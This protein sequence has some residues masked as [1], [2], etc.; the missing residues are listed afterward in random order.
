M[1]RQTSTAPQKSTT[2]RATESARAAGTR[3]ALG[4]LDRMAPRAA[5]RW[6]ARIWCTVP[7][8]AL[9]RDDRPIPGLFVPPST[10]STVTL[11]GRR[12]VTVETWGEGQ[13]VYLVH[14]W[15]GWRGQLGAF[16]EPLLSRGCRVV[17]FDAPSHGDSGPSRHGPHRSTGVEM[18]DALHTIVASYGPPAGIVAHSLGGAVTA[19]AI[20]DGLITVPRLGFVAPTT[21]PLP[22]IDLLVRHMGLSARTRSAMLAHLESML[23]K[24][25]DRFDARHVDATLPPTL[26][27]HDLDDKEVP[28]TEGVELAEAWP[29]ADLV[30]TEELGH[31]R[32]L[33]DPKVLDRVAAFV[34]PLP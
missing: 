22:Y 30:T 18:M 12:K 24:P 6:A 1:T 29:A 28:Y 16:V 21:G 23:G 5:G 33:R 8:G 10:T 17:A 13:P 11:S 27:V 4:V 20:D 9:R 34:A 19:W 14:G 31:Q 25:V 26:I 32:I 3:T 2:V 7:D 15:G